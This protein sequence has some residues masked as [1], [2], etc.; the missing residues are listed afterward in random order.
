MIL[1]EEP[2]GRT[3]MILMRTILAALTIEKIEHNVH[4][5]VEIHHEEYTDHLKMG[6]VN[7]VL[8]VKD[9]C[10]FDGSCG[11]NKGL[12]NFFED[13]LSGWNTL[14]FI[15]VPQNLVGRVSGSS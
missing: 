2:K 6:G 4:T 15:N 8:I 9:D 11:L 3:P 10:S 7:D 13:V 12:M 1:A 14:D 5:C